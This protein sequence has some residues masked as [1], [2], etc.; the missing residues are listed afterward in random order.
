MP[1]LGGSVCAG[2][3]GSVTVSFLHLSTC[4]FTWTGSFLLSLG[5]VSSCSSD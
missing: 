5:R 4:C 2:L 1:S 3:G